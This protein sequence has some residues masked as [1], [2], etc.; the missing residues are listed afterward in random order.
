[1]SGRDDCL[2][3]TVVERFFGSMKKEWLLNI[4]HLPR[5]SMKEDVGGYIRYR[6][7]IK[8]HTYC[9]HIGSRTVCILKT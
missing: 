8:L 6:K 3:N 9:K 4:Y 1:M 5:G 2:D 7:Q